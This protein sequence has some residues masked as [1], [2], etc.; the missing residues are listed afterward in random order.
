M[1]RDPFVVF[2]IVGIAGV[3]V[4]SFFLPVIRLEQSL[5]FGWEVFW[6]SILQLEFAVWAPNPILWLGIVCLWFGRAYF[7]FVAGGLATL[8][9]ALT[10]CPWLMS[11]DWDRSFPPVWERTGAY[12]WLASMLALCIAGLVGSF[13]PSPW[14]AHQTNHPNETYPEL[15]EAAKKSIP[16]HVEMKLPVPI[17]TPM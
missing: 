6:H 1:R 5:F 9:A 11:S 14:P 13:R 8:L 15:C 2:S 7:A 16:D 17:H 3:Y 12:L 10:V 4:A